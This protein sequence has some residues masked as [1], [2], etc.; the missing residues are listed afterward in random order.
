VPQ[1][2]LNRSMVDVFT[3]RQQ[4]WLMAA[5]LYGLRMSRPNHRLDSSKIAES[6]RVEELGR[7]ICGK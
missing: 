6:T 3:Q 2:G 1:P 4:L 5:E 7:G